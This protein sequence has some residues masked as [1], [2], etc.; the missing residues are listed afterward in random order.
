MQFE[1]ACGGVDFLLPAQGDRRA[2]DVQ[3]AARNINLRIA[4]ISKAL[5]SNIP[6]VLLDLLEVAAYVYCADQQTRRGSELL[7]DYGAGWRRRMVFQIPVRSHIIWQREEVRE[8]LENMLGFLSDDHYTFEFVPAKSPLA[9][10]EA[11]FSDL[12]DRTDQPDEIALFSGGMDSF[13][14]VIEAQAEGKKMVLV[15]HHAASKIFNIQKQLIEALNQR[16]S[17]P[18]MFFVPVNITNTGSDPVE[19]TQRTRSFLFATLGVVVARMFGKDEITFY[20]NGVVSLNIP[21]AADVLGARATRTTHPRVIRGFET[22][23]SSILEREINVRTPFQWLTKTDV[24]RKIDEH[25]GA[26]LL[27]K[28]NS[29]T[30]P[31]AMT[32]KQPHCGVCSQCIDRRFAVLAAGLGEVESADLYR[33]DLLTGDRT[34]D[35]DVRMAA[36]YVK[37]FRDFGDVPKD[38]FLAKYTEIVS[39]IDQF[40]DTPRHEAPDRIYDMYLRHHHDVMAVLE[41]A[42]QTNRSELIRGTLPPGSLLAMLHNR[43]RIEVCEPSNYQQDAKEFVDRLS[44]PVLEFAVDAKAHAI[45]FRGDVVLDGKN[46]ELF[47]ALVAPFR[48]GKSEG[49]DVPF[50]SAPKLAAELGITEQSVRQQVGRLREA[51]TEQLVVGQ[52][53]PLDRKSLIESQAGNGYR[54]NPQLRE[55]SLGDLLQQ[56]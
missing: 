27:A 39:A 56:E 38:R 49:E 19:Y 16:A 44:A 35:R 50:V 36:A 7:T 8:G 28:T 47:N 37:F 18:R 3:G 53:L 26:D 25:S 20:E 5:V 11:Y 29:C 48:Q 43:S 10:S 33:V 46:F 14:G 42:A 45:R 34:H 54:I 30:R 52:G 55:L 31:R 24:A 1:F 23:F 22:F 12:T 6:D 13:A 51:V 21:I 41:G 9:A 17:G 2:M 15:G 32:K 40:T 4:D